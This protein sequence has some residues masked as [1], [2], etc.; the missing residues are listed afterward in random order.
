MTFTL[1]G[2]R[3]GKS[4]ALELST[5]DPDAAAGAL[6]TGMRESHEVKARSVTVLKR[7]DPAR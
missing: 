7:V 2:R 3:F 5:A 6:T 4:W 1:P